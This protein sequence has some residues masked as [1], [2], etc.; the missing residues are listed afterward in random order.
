MIQEAIDMNGERIKKMLFYAGL[1]REE[2]EMIND[3]IQEDNHRMIVRASCASTVILMGLV[4]ASF[5]VTGL[6][7]N[8]ILYFVTGIITAVIALLTIFVFPKN[9]KPVLV[10]AYFFLS[11]IFFFAIMLGVP[12][13][14]ESTAT[15]FCVLLFA[16]PLLITDRP[17][18][19]DLFL[20]FVTFCFCTLSMHMKKGSVAV[21]DLTNAVCFL[22][23]SITVNYLITRTKYHDTLV[24]RLAINTYQKHLETSVRNN[25]NYI[26]TFQMNLSSD[27]CGKGISRYPTLLDLKE[28]RTVDG[29]FEQALRWIPYDIEKEAF[30]GLFNREHLL[31]EFNNSNN[32]LSMEH[33]F[34]LQPQ[35]SIWIKTTVDMMRNPLSDQI[36]AIIYVY[37]IHTEKVF[38]A[39][40]SE[41]AINDYEELALVYE[42]TGHF[43]C[44][45]KDNVKRAK[46]KDSFFECLRKNVENDY[47]ENRDVIMEEIS[48]RKI[49]E[50]LEKEETYTVLYTAKRPNERLTRKRIRFFNYSETEQIIFVDKRD[51]T[52]IF[53]LE[54]K[55][56]E[57]LTKALE[58]A[59]KANRAKS[60]F[61]SKISHDIRTPLNGIMGMADLIEEEFNIDKI[62]HYN[63]QI[64][65][66]AK[67]LMGLINDVLDVS[68]IEAGSVVLH[69]EPYRYEEFIEYIEAMMHPL[70]QKKSILFK[71]EN[72]MAVALDV[73]KLRFNQICFNL[74]S[75]SVKYTPEGGT[76]EFL[77]KELERT[78]QTITFTI[79]V[80]DNGMGMSEEFMQHL[81]ERFSQEERRVGNESIQGSGLG[82]SIVKQIVTLMNGT[83]EVH[84]EINKGTEFIVTLT[85]HYFE[86][87]ENVST[88]EKS[89]D[90]EKLD[91]TGK[92]L[93]LC[94]DN[95]INAEIAMNILQNAGFSIEHA[96][97]GAEALETFQQSKTGY[98]DGI[99]MDIR[100][101]VMDGLEATEH[102]RSLKKADALKIPII[103]MTANAFDEDQKMSIDAGMTA[104][105]SKPINRKLLLETLAQYIH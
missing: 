77:M 88:T 74:L 87:D 10:M 94:E 63:R 19:M 81:F 59:K 52:E 100:M 8:F 58:E 57:E 25:E 102:I 31:W 28:A 2:F 95:L 75:N 39:I 76:V 96:E 92:R 15:T 9:R 33:H 7:K 32:Y 5:T 12:M 47:P 40:I 78:E 53:E 50:V 44:F 67:F 72:Q 103:A 60:D 71:K 104:H 56:K 93:L 1:R 26:G 68:K 91:F 105:L 38:Q 48:M 101:P 23:L 16:L 27:T 18:R 66:S 49:Q 69:P 79:T 30:R 42:K 97:N 83:I 6:A 55:S 65:T 70:C 4:V 73:D 29:F 24:E 37:N 20:T 11:L 43:I 13:L 98:Y 46:E 99:L 22:L 41:L 62:H 85:C 35:S 90:Y 64:Q 82:L 86:D 89:I 45:D 84:S 21:L 3:S 80:K 51:V 17:V 34:Q 54:E 36:E 14:K 61:L